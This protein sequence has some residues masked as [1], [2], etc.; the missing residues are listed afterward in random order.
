[1]CM[2]TFM[3]MTSLYKTRNDELFKGITVKRSA[4]RRL[5]TLDFAVL[6]KYC[7]RAQLTSG[8]LSSKNVLVA[9]YCNLLPVHCGKN[10]PTVAC[11]AIFTRGEEA[12][13]ETNQTT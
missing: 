3:K 13:G 12:K 2:R 6:L 10:V 9:I 4:A 5:S 1:M 11:S 7:C 8:K